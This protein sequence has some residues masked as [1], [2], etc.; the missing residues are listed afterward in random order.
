MP[1]ARLWS[2]ENW[3]EVDFFYKKN[4]AENPGR[5]MGKDRSTARRPWRER[6]FPKSFP[7]ADKATVMPVDAQALPIQ[8]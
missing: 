8:P 3:T 4:S 7:S 1:K 6:A 5:Q 2:G